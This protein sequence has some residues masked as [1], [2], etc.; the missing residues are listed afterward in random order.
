MQTKQ[1]K[2]I[3]NAGQKRLKTSDGQWPYLLP[4]GTLLYP[5]LFYRVC[6]VAVQ[7]CQLVYKRLQLHLVP[8]DE[9]MAETQNVENR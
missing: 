5:P 8:V 9:G 1:R 6:I 3:R 7:E 2:N 4:C